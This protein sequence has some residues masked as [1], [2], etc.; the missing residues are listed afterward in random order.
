MIKITKELIKEIVSMNKPT[1]EDYKILYQFIH[2]NLLKNIIIKED[3]LVFL[4]LKKYNL[5]QE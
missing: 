3:K 1:D 2:D 4:A 5:K